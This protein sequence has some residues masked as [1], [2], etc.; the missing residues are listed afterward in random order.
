MRQIEE[1][2]Q[3]FEGEKSSNSEP[4]V[5]SGESSSSTQ[6]PPSSSGRPLAGTWPSPPA[7]KRNARPSRGVAQPYSPPVGYPESVPETESKRDFHSAHSREGTGGTAAQMPVPEPAQTD[8]QA[9]VHDEKPPPLAVSVMNIIVVAAECAP[10]SKTG[11]I[12]SPPFLFEL[13]SRF[14]AFPS[15]TLRPDL[16]SFKPANL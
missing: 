2:Q 15:S 13:S 12:S 14:L 7:S 3:R 5:E 6:T 16:D 1:R 11:K 4:T 10:W 9:P 8:A